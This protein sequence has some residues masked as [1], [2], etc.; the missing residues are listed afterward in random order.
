MKF[1]EINFPVQVL[2]LTA[3]A[4]L[5]SF[6]RMIFF[7]SFHLVYFLWNIFL[8]YLPFILSS[9][10]LW[11]VDHK[12]ISKPAAIC[13][14]I[15]W[16]LLYPN[17][18]YIVT[19]F[20]HLGTS[21][22]VPVWYDILLIFTCAS[23]GLLLGFHSLFHIEHLLKRRFSKHRV[24][25]M[26]MF[27]LGFTSFGIYIGRYLRFNSWDVFTDTAFLSKKIIA[28]LIGTSRFPE[29]YLFSAAFFCFLWV[30]YTAWKY[31]W[32]EPPLHR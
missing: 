27:L 7:G 12:K 8:A 30:F 28:I 24:R 4:I 2:L 17:A 32:K 20:I 25:L 23:A 18:P 15:F 9:V 14:G 22:V 31:S 13:A 29:S 6:G 1:S 16:F 26:V 10:L 19:D 11:H 5:L 21:L 3:F